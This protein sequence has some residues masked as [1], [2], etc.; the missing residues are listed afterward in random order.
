MLI[1]IWS[2][3]IDK[4]ERLSITKFFYNLMCNRKHKM[5][6]PH[7]K[8]LHEKVFEKSL[9][10]RNHFKTNSAVFSVYGFCK[11]YVIY[12]FLRNEI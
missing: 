2:K 5:S 1:I 4:Y 12:M 9:K 6:P 7:D 8:I 11:V 3:K 10:K